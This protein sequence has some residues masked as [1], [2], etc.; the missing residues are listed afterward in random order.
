M[1]SFLFLLVEYSIKKC[2]CFIVK[3]QA[4]KAKQ[5]SCIIV[6]DTGSS[7]P[8]HSGIVSMQG[9]GIWILGKE[10]AG[11]DLGLES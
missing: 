10:R 5:D 11:I 4:M 6:T 9:F 3:F 2:E 8:E 7:E 1:S